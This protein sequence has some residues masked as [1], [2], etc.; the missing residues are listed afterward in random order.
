MKRIGQTKSGGFFCY[1]HF[2]QHNYQADRV[3]KDSFGVETRLISFNHEKRSL[4]SL[5]DRS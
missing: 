4:L 2:L 5:C 1:Y 3:I